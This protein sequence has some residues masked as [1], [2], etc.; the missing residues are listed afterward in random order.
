MFLSA[1]H[2]QVNATPSS[3]AGIPKSFHGV[4][5]INKKSCN[6]KSLSDSRIKILLKEIHGNEKICKLRHVTKNTETAFSGRFACEGEGENWTHNVSIQLIHGR[7]VGYYDGD[8]L[9]KCK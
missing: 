3:M 1:Y 9:I 2:N 6:Y 5:D 8:G 7:L 4:W